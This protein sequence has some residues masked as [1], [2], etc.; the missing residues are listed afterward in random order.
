MNRERQLLDSHL[1]QYLDLREIQD[2]AKKQAALA[3]FREG[4]Y[5]LYNIPSRY[6]FS[7]GIFPPAVAGRLRVDTTRAMRPDVVKISKS[8]QA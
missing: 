4:I 2:E 8:D 3:R 6:F 7:I 1:Q 5:K